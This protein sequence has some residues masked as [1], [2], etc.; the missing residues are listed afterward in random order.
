MTVAEDLARRAGTA[1]DN[2]QSFG[3]ARDSLEA[4]DNFLSLASHELNTPLTSL[5]LQIA[6]LQKGGLEAKHRDRLNLVTRQLN[7]MAKRVKDLLELTR[8]AG[9]QLRMN[10]APVDLLAT[11]P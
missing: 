4:R 7:Q 8:V 3:R 2:A 1:I 10:P 9:G 5:Q 11:G 6:I